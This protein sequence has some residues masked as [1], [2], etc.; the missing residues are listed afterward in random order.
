MYMMGNTQFSM[1]SKIKRWLNIILGLIVVIS[2]AYTLYHYYPRI[3]S[4]HHKGSLHGTEYEFFERFYVKTDGD[5]E[6]FR[7][8]G[9][10]YNVKFDD[11]SKIT[12]DMN[13]WDTKTKESLYFSNIILPKKESEEVLEEIYPEFSAVSLHLY[14][15]H[16]K[17]DSYEVEKLHL[18]K[19]LYVDF[20]RQLYETV[21][22]NK[23]EYSDFSSAMIDVD[24][25]VKLK[26]AYSKLS[27]LAPLYLLA[28]STV[29]GSPIQKNGQA[30]M[31]AYIR[32]LA[33]KDMSSSLAVGNTSCLFAGGILSLPSLDATQRE[34]ITKKFCN[35]QEL[36]ERLEFLHRV[37]SVNE[38]TFENLRGF[39]FGKE[40]DFDFK[41]STPVEAVYTLLDTYAYS[42]VSKRALTTEDI[43]VAE[44]NVA[45]NILDGGYSSKSFKIPFSILGALTYTTGQVGIERYRDIY[46][47]L[48]EIVQNTEKDLLLKKIE[49][50]RSIGLV[51]LLGLSFSDDL[52]IRNLVRANAIKFAYLNVYSKSANN[53]DI[54]GGLWSKDSD[55]NESMFLVDNL[56]YLILLNSVYE[57]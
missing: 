27:S 13:A 33:D 45:K 3:F 34:I 15:K 12:F 55:G 23:K 47:D 4:L 53:N 10:I 43:R 41:S 8:D 29:K 57:E 36:E 16:N 54:Y 19:S 24:G 44:N 49:G 39:V 7:V 52:E 28:M 30:D 40:I 21:I 1:K 32:Q 26:P 6:I 37:E 48:V 25:N 2:L 38:Y 51:T 11:T 5:T 17:L 31:D 50:D 9:I 20:A 22:S 35:V 18:T 46:R 42:S 14:F 56:R